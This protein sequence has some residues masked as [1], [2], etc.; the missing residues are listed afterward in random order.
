MKFEALLMLIT[1]EI[2]RRRFLI[3]LRDKLGL[4]KRKNTVPDLG[5]IKVNC[6]MTDTDFIISNIDDSIVENILRGMYELSGVTSCKVKT[7]NNTIIDW[8]RDPITHVEF[9]QNITGEKILNYAKE[10][11]VDVK[12]I[13]DLGRM[14]ALPLLAIRYSEK[15]DARYI[16]EFI[17]QVTS[18]DEQCGG[19]TGVQWSCVMDV[20]IRAANL[21][22]AYDIFTRLDKDQKIKSTFKTMFARLIFIHGQFIVNNLEIDLINGRNHNHYLADICGILFISNYLDC[23]FSKK[24][25]KFAEK[26][27]LREIK[28]QFMIDG[29]NFES[30]TMYHILSGEMTVYALALMHRKRELPLEVCRRIQRA[31]FFGLDIVKRSGECV[32]IGDNDSGKFFKLSMLTS[33]DKEHPELHVEDHL[34]SYSFLSALSALVTSGHQKDDVYKEGIEYQ[35]VRKLSNKPPIY[36]EDHKSPYISTCNVP[37]CDELV[38]KQINEIFL[39]LGDRYQI[40]DGKWY[41]YPDFGL[42]CYKSIDLNLYVYYGGSDKWPRSHAHHDLLHFEISTPKGDCFSDPGTGWY[43]IQPHWR[44]YFRSEDVHNS[45][46]LVNQEYPKDRT[47]YTEKVYSG[48]L[49]YCDSDRIVV[50]AFNDSVLIRRTISIKKTSLLIED[51]CNKEIISHVEEPEFISKGYGMVESNTKCDFIRIKRG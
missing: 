7:I 47:F 25:K 16:N 50:E 10:Y 2:C 39:D 28:K 27:L 4:P 37:D 14:Q 18:F 42:C 34:T 40:V 5:T 15:R 48:R 23:P 38:F 32:Q 12:A 17:E 6:V 43:N 8:N 45:P 20:G 3:K 30:S 33:S 26:Q 49:V 21:L 41:I 46:H 31:G 13:W 9:P 36:I 24:W 19:C 1:D 44:E 35:L 29:T 11:S 22:V 51:A